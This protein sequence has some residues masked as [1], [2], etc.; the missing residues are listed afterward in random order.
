MKQYKK[1]TLALVLASVITVVGAFGTDLYK[2]SLMS[3]GFKNN[4]NDSVGMV[5][6]TKNGFSHSINPIRRDVNTYEILLPETDSQL[7]SDLPM[8]RNVQNIDIKTLPYSSGGIGYTKITVTTQD[9][10]PLYLETAVAAPKDNVETGNNNSNENDEYRLKQ[11]RERQQDMETMQNMNRPAPTRPTASSQNNDVDIKESVKQFQPSE[12]KVEIPKE[13][14]VENTK[15]QF[16]MTKFILG[17]ILLIFI[18]IFKT[19]YKALIE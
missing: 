12:E 14:K 1:R 15:H 13:E 9:N 16:E 3:L 19:L 8:G 7:S 6:Y 2:N 10:I 4:Q 18:I 17:G 5:I 11:Q